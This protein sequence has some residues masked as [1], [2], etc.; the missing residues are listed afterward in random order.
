MFGDGS[1]S[2]DYTFIKDVIEG[3]KSSIQNLK[4]FEIINL[5]ESKTI[6]LNTVIMTLEKHLGKKALIKQLSQQPGDV[7]T[8]YANITKATNLLNYSPRWEFDDGI[9]EFIKWKMS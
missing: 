4:G 1:T 6:S 3:I 9:R 7:L 8:T 5:G 2:R